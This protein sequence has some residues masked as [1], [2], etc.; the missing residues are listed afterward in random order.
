MT[1]RWY[2]TES[3]RSI[4]SENFEGHFDKLEMS[5][6]QTSGVIGYGVREGVPFYTRQFSFPMFRV[7]PNDTHG[8]Y[9]PECG[10][11]PL[12]LDGKEQF[13]RVEFD[14]VLTIRSR[15]GALGIVRRF[16]P[17]VERPIFYEQVEFF[18]E[19][20]N[21]VFP[22][23]ERVKRFDGRFACEGY[24]YAECVAS[25]PAR[26][27]AAGEKVTVLFGY[28]ARFANGQL[29]LEE[30]PLA[31]RRVRVERLIAECDVTTENDVVD[32]MFAFAKVRAGES[33]FRTSKGLIHC[34]G[35]LTY[36]AAIWC[37]DECEYA[38]PWFAFTSDE[39]EA[40]AIRNI[41][42]WYEPYFNDE[43]S[44]IPSSIICEGRDNFGCA[45]DR[46]DVEMYFYGLTR[47]LL[48][49]G[50]LPDAAQSKVLSW[51]VEFI[52]KNTTAEGV[53]FS[54]SDELENRISSGI[55]LST[56]S[57]AYGGL[58][59]YAVLLE[60]MGQEDKAGEVRSMQL[61]L[62]DA[63]ERYFGGEVSGYH[64]Y[65]YHKGCDVVRAWNCLPVYM[66]IMTRAEGT[67]KSIDKKL[68]TDASC[69]TTEGEDTV[70][71]RSALYF[72]MALLR[73]GKTQLGW[74]RLKEYC[75][76]RLLGDHVP[77][78][79]EAYPEGGMR[80]LS[81]ESALLCRV[82]TDGLLDISFTKEGYRLGCR[83]PQE[84]ERIIVK[85]ISL[86]GKSEDVY[87]ER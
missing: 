42:G 1:M 15:I 27:I 52:R 86:N 50:Q 37:N 39:R 65:R 61:R 44:P 17:S 69:R 78:A 35:G 34:P 36:Y 73:A 23:W 87:V 68:W 71:D 14:G 2:I 81:G 32:T 64:T 3:K 24:V 60:R 57:L 9:Q 66:G 79:V 55:N 10:I 54:D 13:V 5:G 8:S 63:I 40:E 30:N 62:A 84:V 72:I 67:L 25:E 19:G 11:N 28:G 46:G 20:G 51:C 75:A 33:L 21:T 74:E 70:W 26:P 47:V 22:K 12:E 43:Y 41:Y 31:A 16:F 83:L 4:A 77:Y 59:N 49:R 38:A 56:S 80:H 85:D 7:Q 6:E 48:T 53:I 76:N 18:N 82:V 58:D 45:G 29:S